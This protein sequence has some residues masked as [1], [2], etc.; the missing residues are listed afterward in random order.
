MFRASFIN[1]ALEILGIDVAFAAGDPIEPS[2]VTIAER[3]NERLEDIEA[4]LDKLDGEGKPIG[5]YAVFS[6]PGYYSAGGASNLIGWSDTIADAWALVDGVNGTR[7]SFE[8]YDWCHALDVQTGQLHERDGWC[9]TGYGVEH[10][11]EV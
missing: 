1:K 11:G 6:G 10:E 9:K 2:I 4:R 8:K 3:L 7:D 5:R